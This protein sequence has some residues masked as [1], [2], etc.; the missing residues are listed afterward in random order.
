MIADGLRLYARFVGISVR[1]QMQYRASFVMLVIG[2]LGAT[3]VDFLALWALFDRFG[4]LREWSLPE[5]A[6]LYGLVNIAFAIAEGLARGFDRFGTLVRMGEF[7]RVLVRPRSAFLQIVGREVDLSRIGRLLQGAVVFGW[8]AS[9]LAVV[10]TPWKVLLCAAAVGCGACIFIGLLI[11]QATLA[12]W[13]TETLEVMAT[14]TNGGVEASEY[15]LTIYRDWFR[16]LFTFVVPLA[17]AAYYPALAVLD[18][19]DPLGAP[20]WF[21]WASPAIGPAFLLGCF[22]VWRVGVRHYMSTGS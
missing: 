14:V 4:S 1:S 22:A 2:H 20:G 11:L 6:L 8:G 7:D 13:T 21:L 12:F 3:V 17:C 9:A 5:V 18:R 19:A 15:P 16:R 10:W